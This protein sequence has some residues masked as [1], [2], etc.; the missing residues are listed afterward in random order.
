MVNNW[1]LKQA[2]LDGAHVWQNGHLSYPGL[3]DVMKAMLGAPITLD[4]VGRGAHSPLS[5]L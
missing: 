3:A 2:V 1:E 4:E 5:H